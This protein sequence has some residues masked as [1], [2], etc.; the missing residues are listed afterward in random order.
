M[1]AGFDGEP[2]ELLQG[3]SDVFSRGSSGDDTSSCILDQLEFMEWFPQKTMEERI[4]V[5]QTGCNQG[6]Y[7]NGR[8]GWS[9]FWD[10]YGIYILILYCLCDLTL[11]GTYSEHTYVQ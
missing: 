9:K 5:V 1:N 10:I 11:V 6:V 8:A 7:R 4:T 2:V 3:W